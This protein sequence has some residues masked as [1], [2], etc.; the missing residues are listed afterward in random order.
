MLECVPS[1]M[2]HLPLECSYGAV[3]Q[4]CEGT[5]VL[6]LWAVFSAGSVYYCPGIKIEVAGTAKPVIKRGS[7]FRVRHDGLK[8]LYRGSA[9]VSIT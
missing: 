5:D 3:A 9:M 1:L 8:G 7:Q 4:L 6:L 2:L